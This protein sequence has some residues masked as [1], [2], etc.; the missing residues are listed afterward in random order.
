MS[1]CRWSSDDFRCDVYVYESEEGWRTHVAAVRVV[2]SG[3]LPD[4]IPPLA[5]DAGR[6]QLEA[7]AEGVVARNR[8]VRALAVE[9]QPI[10]L[11]CDGASYIDPTPG[12][13]ADTLARLLAMGYHVPQEVID[14]LREEQ[15]ERL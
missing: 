11:P 8:A 1:Y 13:C 4:P 2:H 12:A 10:G 5:P 3:P 15:A 6:A 9:R 7:W 14:D